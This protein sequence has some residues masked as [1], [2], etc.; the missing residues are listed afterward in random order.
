M[1][2]QTK[3]AVTGERTPARKLPDSCAAAQPREQSHEQTGKPMTFLNRLETY[4][5]AGQKAGKA[6]SRKDYR[7]RSFHC[8]WLRRALALESQPYRDE[9]HAAFDEAYCIETGVIKHI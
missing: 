8:D 4:R 7:L 3:T 6:Q 1:Q 5:D 2:T 9:A